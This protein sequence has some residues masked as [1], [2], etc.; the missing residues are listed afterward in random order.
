MATYVL[1]RLLGLIPVL[2]GISLVVF[3]R[4]KLIPGD[5]AQA[6]LGLTARPE[7][8]RSSSLLDMA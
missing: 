8:N 2:F 5:V 3:F 1:R 7:D 4:M 6:L